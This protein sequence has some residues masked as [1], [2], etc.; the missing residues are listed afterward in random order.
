MTQ[1]YGGDTRTI[2]PNKKTVQCYQFITQ[3]ANS[4]IH[5]CCQFMTTRTT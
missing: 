1:A 5:F 2:E 3:I 4:E